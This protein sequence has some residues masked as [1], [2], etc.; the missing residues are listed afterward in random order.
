MANLLV[1]YIHVAFDLTAKVKA[2]LAELQLQQ[3]N[4]TDKG[5]APALATVGQQCRR[6]QSKSGMQTTP[7]AGIRSRT[8]GHGS[9]ALPASKSASMKETRGN[10]SSGLIGSSPELGGSGRSTAASAKNSGA[11]SAHA[12][13]STSAGRVKADASA[14]AAGV[15]KPRSAVAEFRQSSS[16]L[17]PAGVNRIPDT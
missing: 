5:T 15:H 14:A 6:P 7:A 10:S 12:R 3:A 8:S 11:A 4:A 1:I 16:Q 9:A 17:L 13:G 2:A